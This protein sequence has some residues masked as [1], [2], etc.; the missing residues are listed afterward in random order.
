MIISLKNKI[1]NCKIVEV[2][3]IFIKSL[4]LDHKINKTKEK[5]IIYT[6]KR[7]NR[8]LIKNYKFFYLI[9]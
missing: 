4:K 8:N 5:K 9:N 2:C 1:I 6:N 3:L 7:M